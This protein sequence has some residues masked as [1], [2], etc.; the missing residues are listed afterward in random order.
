M[1]SK[2]KWNKSY[3]DGKNPWR[4]REI[5]L[6]NWLEKSG[7]FNGSALDLGCGTGE[8]ARWL[9]QHGFMVEGIDFSEEAIKIASKQPSLPGLFFNVW[10]L[11][12]LATYSFK[13][14]AY[15]LII[16]SKTLVFI[17][18]KEKYLATIASKLNGV[19]ILQVIIKHAEKP[20]LVVQQ[21]ELEE[22]LV[23]YFIIKG[24]DLYYKPTKENPLSVVAEYFLVKKE[25]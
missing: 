17:E 3:R 8:V 15:D 11:E 6:S 2:E 16:D 19:F 10:D 1:A 14:R 25:T 12:E 4:R 9:A 18:D 23:K 21:N 22:I 13:N 5:N 7:V 20:F 24:I